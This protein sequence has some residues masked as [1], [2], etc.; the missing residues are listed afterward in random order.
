MLILLVLPETEC[1]RLCSPYYRGSLG[2]KHEQGEKTIKQD[3]TPLTHFSPTSPRGSPMGASGT[4][5]SKATDSVNSCC[6]NSGPKNQNPKTQHMPFMPPAPQLQQK[7]R[8]YWK[9]LQNTHTF[10][11]RE[12]LSRGSCY[13]KISLSG[14]S[15]FRK[16]ICVT[17][18]A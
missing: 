1:V 16:Y 5:V 7:L 3:G 13:A 17:D 10:I 14:P 12:Q 11:F 15:Y 4:Q 2:V 9:I 8:D 6:P 18:Q